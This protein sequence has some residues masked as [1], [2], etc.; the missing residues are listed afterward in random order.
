M[1]GSSETP[2]RTLVTFS[3]N[4][5][6]N[7]RHFWNGIHNKPLNMDLR[8]SSKSLKPL[9]VSRESTQAKGTPPTPHHKQLFDIW[10]L[11]LNLW[12]IPAPP[13]TYWRHFSNP[14][15][16]PNTQWAFLKN[17]TLSQTSQ[18]QPRMQ[19]TSRK[20]VKNPN[21]ILLYSYLNKAHWKL[22]KH[23][24]RFCNTHRYLVNVPGTSSRA[25]NNITGTWGT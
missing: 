19:G 16:H 17:W 24:W 10:Y 21:I 8:A 22:I 25:F 5:W 15:L 23:S 1:P 11:W 3:Q 20:T 12:D 2:F 7:I 9:Q 14:L 13:E 18:I 4:P 6:N